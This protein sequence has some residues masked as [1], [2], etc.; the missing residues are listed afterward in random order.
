MWTYFF[1]AFENIFYGILFNLEIAGKIIKLYQA[2]LLRNAPE[3]VLPRYDK[4]SSP[5]FTNIV[6]LP[7][8]L[9]VDDQLLMTC[10]GLDSLMTNANACSLDSTF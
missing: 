1:V 5:Y 2:S 3:Q 4:L 9:C 6:T 7:P 10:C 8:L